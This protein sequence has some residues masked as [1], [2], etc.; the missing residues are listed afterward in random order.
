LKKIIFKKL[1]SN[2][3]VI[4]IVTKIVIK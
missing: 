1:Y 3:I 4:K 2:V